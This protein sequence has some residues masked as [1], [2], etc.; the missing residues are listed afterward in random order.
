MQ[1]SCRLFDVF[2][3]DGL[4]WC[5]QWEWPPL[6]LLWVN[7]ETAKYT[8]GRHNVN[9]VF[10]SRGGETPVSNIHNVK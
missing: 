2:S 5:L 3:I 10:E 1:P 9:I 4:L 8:T 7:G 6:C